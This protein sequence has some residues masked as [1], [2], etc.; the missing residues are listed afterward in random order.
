VN[1][2]L[3]DTNIVSVLFNQNHSLRPAC[4]AAAEGRQL[5]ISFMSL[6]ELLLW[7]VANNWGAS[8]RATL[9]AHLER[10]TTIFPDE[11]TCT[12][13]SETVDRRRRAGKPIHTA[14]AWIA[15][16]ALQWRIP[17]L[18][19]DFRDYETIDDLEVIPIR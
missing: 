19:A 10:Y 2:L 17:L 6:A 15:S 8:R 12:I 9:D 16:S 1:V 13:W 4:I 7:P 5:A 3:L 18:T 14:D 11:R